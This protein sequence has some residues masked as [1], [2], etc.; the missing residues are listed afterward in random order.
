MFTPINNVEIL[1]KKRLVMIVW[2]LDEYTQNFITIGQVNIP[3][4]SFI[5]VDNTYHMQN[6]MDLTLANEVVGKVNL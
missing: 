6:S 2:Y 4:M 1:Q 5:H 3:I